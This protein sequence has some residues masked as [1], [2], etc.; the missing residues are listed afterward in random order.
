MPFDT[1]SRLAQNTNFVRIS[2]VIASG[3]WG[4]FWIPLRAL[5]EH[6][7]SPSVATTLFYALPALLMLP[8]AIAR[9][10][11]LIAGGLHL[12][13]MGLFLG[14]S[15]WLYANAYYFTDIIRVLLLYY[16]LP[17][18]GTI[19]GCL[20]LSEK[21]TVSRVIGIVL[22][23]SGMLVMFGLGEGLPLPRNLGDWLALVAGIIWAIGSAITKN[24]EVSHPFEITFSFFA[25]ATVVGVAIMLFTDVGQTIGHHTEILTDVLPWMLLVTV[26]L[27]FPAI[28]TVIW[29]AGIL[30]PG[31][32]GI[33]FMSEIS[34]G[35]VGA[36]L[37]TDEVIGTRELIGI[38][39]I[40]SAGL[41]EAIGLP[42]REEP[43][44]TTPS[45][46]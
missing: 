20:F 34:V 10:R 24:D 43:S 4:L 5:E 11:R 28:F 8:F 16:L 31:H 9:R 12:L 46:V 21:L 23:L 33:L 22:G 7:L 19:L 15:M 6:G 29:G 1:V 42:R 41:A 40:T 45:E 18:W 13:I 36:A 32:L 25:W 2:V 38:L 17:V 27:T 39:L 35:A 44:E 30:S 14:G 37:L 26:L 3:S